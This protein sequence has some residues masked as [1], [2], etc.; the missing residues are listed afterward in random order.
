[1]SSTYIHTYRQIQGTAYRFFY[2]KKDN[3]II[4]EFAGAG[5]FIILPFFKMKRNLEFHRIE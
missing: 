1:M 4:H 3:F 2:G 5:G